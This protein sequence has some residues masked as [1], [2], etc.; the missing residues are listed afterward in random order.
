[1]LWHAYALLC[2]GRRDKTFPEFKASKKRVFLKYLWNTF[3]GSQTFDAPRP[4]VPI[5][6]FMR[7][8]TFYSLSIGRIARFVLLLTL[9]RG[10]HDTAW[11]G[12][13]PRTVAGTGAGH[14]SLAE[15][16]NPNGTL[17]AGVTG[18]FDATGYR[19]AAGRHG[20]PVFRPT[21]ATGA[22]DEKWKEGFGLAGTNGAIRALV[23][24][25]TDVYAGGDFTIAGAAVA[26]YVA[27]WDGTTWTALGGGT[28]GPVLALAVNGNDVYAG[29][30]FTQAAGIQANYVAKWNGNTW[31]A[32]GFGTDGPVNAL[33]V[34][35]TDVYAGG[36]FSSAS[37]VL[38]NRIAKWDGNA[39][40]A[41]GPGVGPAGTGPGAT[42]T[43][44]AVSGSDLYVGGDFTYA[45]LVA[46]SRVAKW[47]GT[48]WSALGAGTD[49]RVFALAVVGTDVYAGGQFGTAGGVLTGGVAKWNGTS[50]SSLSTGQLLGTV[51]A[52][53]ASGTD[54]YAGGDFTS[55][56]GQPQAQAYRIAKWNGSA[57]STL[58]TGL[59][60]AMSPSVNV[61]ALA[62]RGAEL[63][64]GGN[65]TVAGGVPATYAAS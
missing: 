56:V 10:G 65:F 44:L 8:Y 52:L 60:A 50:W 26:N 6:F 18:S 39:W 28:N 32:L 57:W 21:G 40:S 3:T 63:L 27:K 4:R 47:N 34:S 22:G 38:T 20:K 49:S 16:L 53:A 1:M 9:L 19:L 55:A 17:R 54:V 59:G 31:S 29:G 23:V 61:Q 5:T 35:G 25:G 33:A 48:A 11:A 36:G 2:H 14:A 24:S 51:R 7:I 64:M 43:A 62:V 42:V 30:N 46:A 12:T 41:L 37:G 13:N 45:G 15:V 58:G